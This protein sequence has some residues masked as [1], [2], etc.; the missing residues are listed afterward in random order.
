MKNVN[1]IK[2]ANGEELIDL[3]NDTV[4]KEVLVKGYTAHDSTGE[5]IEGELDVSNADT[6]DGLHFQVL[7]SAP[8]ENNT[9][10]LTIVARL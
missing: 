8:T 1:H 7:P 4:T 9:A 6:V 10:M 2:L 3:R 5:P